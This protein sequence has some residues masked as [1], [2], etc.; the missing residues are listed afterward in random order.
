MKAS[1]GTSTRPI[2]AERDKSLSGKVGETNPAE[3]F[4][5]SIQAEC[6]GPAGTLANLFQIGEMEIDEMPECR[7]IDAATCARLFAAINPAFLSERPFL[8]VPAMPEGF[9]DVPS[10]STHRGSPIARRESNEG[11]QRAL[12]MCGRW[13]K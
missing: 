4:V 13:S 7:R 6:F 12:S 10:L 3:L 11:C 8:G 1:C 9:A 5:Q 2:S